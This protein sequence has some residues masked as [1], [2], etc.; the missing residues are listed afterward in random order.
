MSDLESL[1]HASLAK[2]ARERGNTLTVVKP[3]P[4]EHDEGDDDSC[5]ECVRARGLSEDD[6][7]LMARSLR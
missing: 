3:L 5:A 6:R 7:A 1:L 4:H 2:L